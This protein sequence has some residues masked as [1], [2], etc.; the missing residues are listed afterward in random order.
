MPKSLTTVA[1]LCRNPARF[2][3]IWKE[4]Q[5]VARLR[6][7]AFYF[8][9]ADSFSVS[10][11]NPPHRIELATYNAYLNGHAHAGNVKRAEEVPELLR[12]VLLLFFLRHTLSAR[13]YRSCR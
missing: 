8:I 7:L 1:V 3:E 6:P 4:L 9:F 11:K 2:E 13:I 12:A 5:G 10:E